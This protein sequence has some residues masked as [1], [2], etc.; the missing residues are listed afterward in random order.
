VAGYFGGRFGHVVMR[1]ADVVLSVPVL[2]FVLAVI[3]IVGPGL[4]GF[5]IAIPLVS[6]APYA[7]VTR[8]EMLVVREKDYISAGRSLGYSPSRILLRHA[9][10][11]VWRS[12]IVF[13]MSDLIGNIML[14]AALSFLGLGVQP[15]TPEWGAI[16]ADG[17][18]TLTT[19]WW[20]STLPGFFVVLVGI[21]FS[22]IGDGLSEMVGSPV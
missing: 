14:L 3:A 20:V 22:M 2:V 13:S 9:L 15:P 17:Q 5:L 10:P 6:W 4:I 11:N 7:R 12:S 8:A 1:V 18:S 19:A 16:I 21:G